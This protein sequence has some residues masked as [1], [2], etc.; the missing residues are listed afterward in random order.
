MFWSLRFGGFAALSG[1]FSIFAVL[2]CSVARGEWAFQAIRSFGFTNVMGKELRAGVI[3]AENGW[4][5]GT[6]R[7]GGTRGSGTV[8]KVN[9]DGT[10]LAVLKHF[11]TAD[12]EGIF[13]NELI[14]G[15]DGVLYGTTWG[16]RG[17]GPG[18]GT[19]FRINPDGSGFLLL[20]AL[21]DP[22]VEGINPAAGLV[23]GSDGLL[24]GTT[25]AG[26][27]AD[28]GAV[29]RLSKGG[30]NFEVIWHFGVTTND[31]RQPQASLI[32]GGNGALYG[33]TYSGG[34]SNAGT[35]FKLNK[36]GSGYATLRDLGQDY[37]PKWPMGR[38]LQGSDGALYGT[39]PVVGTITEPYFS[40][41]VFRLMPDGSQWTN[42]FLF[43]F[44][45]HFPAAGLIEGADGAL[46]GTLSRGGLSS[47][48]YGS[49][50]KINKDGSGYTRLKRFS[51]ASVLDA[52]RPV[53]PLFQ[54]SDGRLYGTTE[55]GGAF[56]D[57]AVFA[58]ST[59]GSDYRI[60]ADK[61]GTGTDGEQPNELTQASDGL[62]Y[63]TTIYGGARMGTIF[64]ISS[65]GSNYEVLRRFGRTGR[66]G[67][68][69]VAGV[70]EGSDGW[71]Y[72]TTRN[73]GEWDYG[74]IFR[75]GKDGSNYTILRNFHS[76]QVDARS[77]TAALLEGSD[78]WL[79]GTSSQG[80]SNT[81]G[82]IFRISRDGDNFAILHHFGG[83]DNSY[84]PV[85]SV[86]EA[87]DG[88][89]YGTTF[90]SIFRIQKDGTGYTRLFSFNSTTTGY[91]SSAALL[92][93]SDG[94]L[95]G[96]VPMGGTN[97]AAG[98]VFRIRKDGTQFT[99][100]K[101]FYPS[102]FD[103]HAPRA[104]LVEGAD[105]TLYGT[106]SVGGSQQ[107]YGTV[108]AINKNGSQY[109]VLRSFSGQDS[110]GFWP[111]AALKKGSDGALYGTA[112]SGGNSRFGTVFRLLPVP[113]LSI[114][115]QALAS[116]RVIHCNWLQNGFQWRLV[117][118]ANVDTPDHLWS[119]V[120]GAAES[121][122]TLVVPA[123]SRAFFRLMLAP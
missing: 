59:N 57:G 90:R 31:G 6:T 34:T 86:I 103:G 36:D 18:S 116:G 102:A 27:S 74:T 23:E 105:G 21:G 54:A 75:I 53:A 45:E 55:S 30:S 109:R 46:Y 29:F 119:A 9:K 1:M 35:V 44:S 28:G 68:N 123:D 99:P 14:E 118:H 17:Y 84:A 62:W 25:E 67:Q 89:L 122:Y 61:S 41:V 20:K 12:G 82:T 42:L 38:L 3:E 83:E 32:E 2:G 108:F 64:R 95:Y 77:P 26:G 92:E 65:D 51:S 80:G 70:I 56:G 113:A 88:A 22:D 69:P 39:A 96:T 49:I 87:S 16:T 101:F 47:D 94:Q 81:L 97:M 79:Y 76:V 114:R 50:F 43:Q 93:A 110:R 19:V 15:S 100:L 13:P 52:A 121:D 117:S 112:A 104:P 106:C 111:N 85:A 66:D 72:G 37:G 91:G 71:M 7:S 10:G 60:V 11:S 115:G 78:G 73:G 58:L 98:T 4:L 8:F 5:Y 120:Q 107:V 48:A 63:G 24:Y 33:T 40:G